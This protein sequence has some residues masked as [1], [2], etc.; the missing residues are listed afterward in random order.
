[1]DVHD[2]PFQNGGTKTQK[3]V[4]S[5]TSNKNKKLFYS[6]PTAYRGLEKP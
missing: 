4:I 6:T 3:A 5:E 1:M 2:E